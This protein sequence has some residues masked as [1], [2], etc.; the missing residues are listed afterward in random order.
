M[1]NKNFFYI[2]KCRCCNSKK[3]KKILNLGN[4]P[5]ANNLLN[6]EKEE[7]YLYPLELNYCS[8]CHNCQLSICVN[9]SVL[10]DKYLYLS[11]VS[12]TFKNHFKSAAKK[13]IS[14]LNLNK[15]SFIIDIGS[16]DGVGLMPFKS[17]GFNNILAIEPAKNLAKIS[18]EKGIKT[19]N[20]YFNKKVIKRI[21][22]KADLIL[23]SNVF[24][25][26][27]DLRDMAQCML[28][29]LSLKGSIVIEVQYL[30]RTLKDLTF[31]NI[32][33]EHYNYWSLT[34]LNYFFNKLNVKIYR[35]EIIN[36][37]GGSIRIYI[38]KNKFVKVEKNVKN[39]LNNEEKFGLKN[40]KTYRKFSNKVKTIKK[41]VSSN[42]KKISKK[43]K[44]II[45]YGAPAKATT[46]LNFYS[47]KN[48]RMIIIEDNKLKQGKIL[49]GVQ[50]PI[51]PKDMLK[52]NRA[53]LVIILAWNFTKEI[54]KKNKFISKK[55]LSIKKLEKKNLKI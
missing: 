32:Y 8:N 47:I 4:Q 52:K 28:D 48:R 19:Y 45:F 27:H 26:A 23:A 55:F 36:T 15:N 43:Y 41:N 10:F 54:K 37:H 9:P 22:K 38:T 39:I 12:N 44:K 5:L 2:R 33:H 53:E 18:K 49:P 16:N 1:K 51:F 30:L 7:F 34:S 13:Y 3:L 31:D 46:A 11:S 35:A 29:I 24:A 17:S 6:N 21:K 42:I 50:I 14:T 20:S 40:I 25:H